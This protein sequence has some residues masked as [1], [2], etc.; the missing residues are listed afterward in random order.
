MIFTLL[1]TSRPDNAAGVWR[2]LCHIERIVG[3]T[4]TLDI[5]C[6]HHVGLTVAFWY[7]RVLLCDPPV[8]SAS[9]DASHFDKRMNAETLDG[10]LH[11]NARLPS[12]QCHRTYCQQFVRPSRVVCINSCIYKCIYEMYRVV[13]NEVDCFIS[14]P[15]DYNT[16]IV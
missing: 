4:L 8:Y 5:L 2:R 11:N 13:H 7:L 3:R 15:A 10:S 1:S 9:N 14:S 12:A 6:C 16:C